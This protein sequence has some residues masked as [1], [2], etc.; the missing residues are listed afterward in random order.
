MNVLRNP[1]RSSRRQVVASGNTAGEKVERMPV[2]ECYACGERTDI[3]IKNQLRKGLFLSRCMRCVSR[4][5]WPHD[6]DN[7]RRSKEEEKEKEE[8]KDN[9]GK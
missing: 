9:E 2:R 7:I 4:D 3:F 8:K 1:K 6:W 5:L